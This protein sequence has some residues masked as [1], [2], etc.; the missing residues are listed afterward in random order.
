MGVERLTAC[1]DCGRIVTL[2]EHE[3]NA[4]RGTCLAC[5]AR[6]D[7]VPERMI[8]PPRTAPPS[9]PMRTLGTPGLVMTRG[10]AAP[11]NSS[12]LE[13]KQSPDTLALFIHPERR[14]LGLLLACIGAGWSTIILYFFLALTA[15]PH[16]GLAVGFSLFLVPFGVAGCWMMGGALRYLAGREELTIGPDQIVQRRGL[17]GIWRTRR[18]PLAELEG[19]SIEEPERGEDGELSEARLAAHFSGRRRWRLAD[20][21]GHGKES[22]YWLWRR[23]ER[24]LRQRPGTRG[25]P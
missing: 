23:L 24:E 7:L 10:P 9:E 16:A 22:M 13:S 12:I 11:P 3:L 14:S 25:C 4:K 17:C 6:F 5:D 20:G 2:A 19:L 21:L 1:P 8:G 15:L 18:A